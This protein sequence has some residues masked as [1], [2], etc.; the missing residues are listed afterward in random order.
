[1][2]HESVSVQVHVRHIKATLAQH[3]ILRDSQQH[4]YEGLSSTTAIVLVYG[5]VEARSYYSYTVAR[6]LA[7]TRLM[8]IRDNLKHV[9][10]KMMT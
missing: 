5:W 2:Q 3:G 6:H 8:E 10:K 1:M 7:I 4:A 9:E